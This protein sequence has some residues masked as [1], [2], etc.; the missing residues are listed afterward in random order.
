MS[1]LGEKKKKKKKEKKKKK[2]KNQKK[3]KKQQNSFQ[4]EEKK[5]EAKSR[6][7]GEGASVLTF[8][9][10]QRKLISKGPG[11]PSL[12]KKPNPYSKRGFGAERGRRF[13][14]G[15]GKLPIHS[16]DTKKV[17]TT[18]SAMKKR[19]DNQGAGGKGKEDI[20]YSSQGG[21]RHG[22]F[23]ET[24]GQGARRREGG[25]AFFHDEKGGKL[26]SNGGVL[27]SITEGELGLSPFI[28]EGR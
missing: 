23:G 25:R 9:L 11:L 6:Q 12:I 8:A 18:P 2:K 5:R 27:P 24:F 26:R 21:E 10:Y 22:S 20:V 17:A 1:F 13:G 15:R 3:K 4:T 19:G 7:R 28:K 14:F 16:L